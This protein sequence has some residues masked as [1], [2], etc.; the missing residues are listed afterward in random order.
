M[1]I[2]EPALTVVAHREADNSRKEQNM[3]SIKVLDA[4]DLKFF[5]SIEVRG[6]HPGDGEHITFPPFCICCCEP[7]FGHIDIHKMVSESQNFGNITKR[8]HLGTKYQFRVCELCQEHF[9]NRIVR[10]VLL[11]AILRFATYFVPIIAIILL[12]CAHS[13]R[14]ESGRGLFRRETG[15]CT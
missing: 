6:I 15:R 5:A 9:D 1:C 2:A 11:R 4:L 7:T 12:S 3:K 8:V 10:R 13:S 14:H